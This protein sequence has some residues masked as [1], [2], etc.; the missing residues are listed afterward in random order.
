MATRYTTD[1]QVNG[2][3]IY[4]TGYYVYY[5]I[6]RKRKE[7]KI[8]NK[9][10]PINVARNIARQ[11]LGEVA[12]GIDPLAVKKAD[13]EAITLNDAFELKLKD[14][15]DNNKKCV[16]LKDGEIDGEPKRMW[17]KDVRNTLG[18]SK[19]EDIETGDIT[20]LHIKISKRA[21]YQ[22]NR[23]SSAY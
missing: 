23:S 18:K 21:K 22:A 7:M 17:D 5:R 20:K 19:L 9:D 4:P 6:N 11:K 3:R 10:I 2:L 15:F 16:Y 1:K 14:L 13:V 8:A 12:S